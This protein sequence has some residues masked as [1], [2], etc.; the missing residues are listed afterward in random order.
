MQY[1]SM[2]KPPDR[3]IS[4]GMVHIGGA[5]ESWV[6]VRYHNPATPDE[7]VSNWMIPGTYDDYAR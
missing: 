1:Q 6:D 4:V 7:P 3:I 5:R 2:K